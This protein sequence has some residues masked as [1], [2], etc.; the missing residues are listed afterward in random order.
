MEAVQV[1]LEKY[2]FLL[3]SHSSVSSAICFDVVIYKTYSIFILNLAR[4]GHNYF[5]KKYQ[6][7]LLNLF[8]L[9]VNWYGC[10]S[11]EV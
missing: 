8:Y 9:G 4:F 2:L 7:T 11:F 10:K 6:F 1:F 3:V 5:E